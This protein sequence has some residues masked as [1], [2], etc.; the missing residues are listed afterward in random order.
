MKN[1]KFVDNMVNE[2]KGNLL[3]S[4]DE[5]KANREVTFQIWKKLIEIILSVTGDVVSLTRR[6]TF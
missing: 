4:V 1:I 2:N 6:Y 3:F 5:F